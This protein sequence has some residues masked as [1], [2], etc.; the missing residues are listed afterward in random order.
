VTSS[1]K[2]STKKAV[3]GSRIRRDPP[4]APR[5]LA[6]PPSRERDIMIGIVGI[7]LFAL[8][9]TTLTVSFSAITAD[10]HQGLAI[11]PPP[12]AQGQPPSR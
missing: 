1:A 2:L 3:R 5:K 6:P 8:A 9:I 4:P 10:E 12:A 7:I 11:A